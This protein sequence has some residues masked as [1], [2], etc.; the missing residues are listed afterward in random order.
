M[1][2]I[3]NVLIYSKIIKKVNTNNNYF[4]DSYYNDYINTFFTVVFLDCILCIFIGFKARYFQLHTVINL[5]ITVRIL[6]DVINLISNPVS[7]YKLLENHYE[8]NLILSLHLYHVLISKNLNMIELFHHI[9]FVGFGIIPTIMYIKTNQIYLGYIACS[10]IPGIFEYGLLTLLKNNIITSNVQKKLTA[11][12]YNYIR[13]PLALFGCY[14]NYFS[15]KYNKI[16]KKEIF[17]MTLY[18][19]ILLFLNGTVF[20]QLTLKSYYIK[21]Q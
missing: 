19:N 6:P 3:Q 5:I 20:N 16:I 13:C 9:L 11:Y 15:W 8:S 17:G 7:N 1:H 14:I 4:L 18:I 10:G 12:L 2:I 21:K